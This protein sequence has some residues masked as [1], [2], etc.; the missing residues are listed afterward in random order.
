LTGYGQAEDVARA[1]EA[2]FDVHIVKP[3]DMRAVCEAID[4]APT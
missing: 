1:H 2:G 3:V 4:A